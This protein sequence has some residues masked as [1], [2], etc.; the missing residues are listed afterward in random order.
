MAQIC[1]RGTVWLWHN[2]KPLS[3]EVSNAQIVKNLNA[4]SAN[5]VHFLNIYLLSIPTKTLQVKHW[6]SIF[7]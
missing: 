6:N 1:N 2:I 5:Q 3:M 4:I 7:L